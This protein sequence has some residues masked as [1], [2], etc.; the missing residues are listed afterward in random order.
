[1]RRL[2]GS[3]LVK[4]EALLF[5]SIVFI[6]IFLTFV[7]ISEVY[8]EQIIALIIP[9]FMIAVIFILYKSKLSDLSYEVIDYGDYLLFKKGDVSQLVDFSEIR[10]VYGE[11]GKPERIIIELK[12]KGNLGRCLVFAVPERF[13]QYTENPIVVELRGRVKESKHAR[14]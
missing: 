10:H 8:K 13:F 2:S 12:E 14:G 4:K 6:V 3:T 5:F 7:L 11:K 1:M 9:I